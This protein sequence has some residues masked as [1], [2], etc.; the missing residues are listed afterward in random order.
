MNKSFVI[1][2]NYLCFV[3]CVLFQYSLLVS[4]KLHSIDIFMCL[5]LG[6]KRDIWLQSCTLTLTASKTQRLFMY[7][8]VLQSY[9]LKFRLRLH[10]LRISSLNSLCSCYVRVE[11][12]FRGSNCILYELIVYEVPSSEFRSP[13][14]INQE[15]C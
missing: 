12:F 5:W 6:F 1:S 11:M 15:G 8:F 2:F 7:T 3:I 14:S 9:R 10:N 4:F 13:M